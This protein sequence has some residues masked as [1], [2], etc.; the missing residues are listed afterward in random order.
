MFFIIS[1]YLLLTEDKRGIKWERERKGSVACGKHHKGVIRKVTGV[2]CP[3]P[4]STN[5]VSTPYP[6]NLGLEFDLLQPTEWD[7]SNM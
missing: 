2:V 5:S 4:L 1:Y 3:I 7:I 6:M